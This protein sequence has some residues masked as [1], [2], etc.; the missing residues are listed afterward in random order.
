MF[1]VIYNQFVA[2]IE[3]EGHDRGYLAFLVV[4]GVGITIAGYGLDVGYN[5]AER[6]FWYFMASGTPMIAGSVWRFW[7]KRQQEESVIRHI[8]EKT[9]ND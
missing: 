1:G 2:W 9:N 7:R 5:L 3:S 8:T 4:I 6:L